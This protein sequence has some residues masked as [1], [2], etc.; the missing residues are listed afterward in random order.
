MANAIIL[1][2]RRSEKIEPGSQSFTSNGVFVAPYTAVYWLSVT[3]SRAKSGDGGKGGNSHRDQKSWN[4]NSYIC[5][6]GGGGGGG[7]AQPA[8][9][10]TVQFELNKGQEVQVTVNGSVVS[11]G[12]Y[13][14]CATGV[15][16]ENGGA[17][18]NWDESSGSQSGYHYGGYG[19]EGGRPPVITGTLGYAS[20][21]DLEAG[22]SGTAG[23]NGSGSSISGSPDVGDGTGPVSGGNG[24]R[25][26]T[27]IYGGDGSDAP[28]IEFPNR[29][30]YSEN[31]GT[32]TSAVTGSIT[33]SWGGTGAINNY[34]GS[35][36]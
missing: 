27:L 19:G 8:V 4:Q 25:T 6:G 13:T 16:G 18:D 28:R 23:K 3:G 5:G 12:N 36:P 24:G 2:R 29:N 20:A 26:T 22:V 14:S 30:A 7:A 1:H 9:Y 35:N 11:F 21:P 15:A 32:G 31:G 17:G 10:T 33:V 34:G